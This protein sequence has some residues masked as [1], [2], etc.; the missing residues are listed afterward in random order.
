LFRIYPPKADAPLAQKLEF[1]IYIIMNTFVS[2]ISRFLLGG[3]VR[4]FLIKEIKGWE[5]VPKTKNFILASNH[6]SHMDWFMSGYICSPKKFTFVAQ[7][8]QYTGFKK[9]WRNLIYLWGGVIPINRKSSESKKWAVDTAIKML[10]QGY[11][12]V[13]YPEGG[14]A[15]DGVMREFK[16]GVGKL[17]LD[18]GVSVLPAALD[19]TQKLMPPHGRLKLAKVARVNIGKLMDFSKE[20]EVAAKLDKDSREYYDLCVDVTKKIEKTVRELAK[21]NAN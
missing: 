15:Y 18:S 2:T 11:R 1:R 19:G 9:L 21:K 6:L 5:N 16:A 14:R 10:A 20:R 17:C 4:S 13:I 8:D 3:A 12:V 7:V